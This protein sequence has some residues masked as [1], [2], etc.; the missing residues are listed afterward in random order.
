M[1]TL[2]TYLLTYLL[3]GNT[4]STAVGCLKP[5][6][7]CSS[8]LLHKEANLRSPSIWSEFIS[9]HAYVSW[10]VS[11]TQLFWQ[12]YHLNNT[13]LLL[14]CHI[15]RTIAWQLHNFNNTILLLRWH[16]RG[17]SALVAV[18][19]Y[20]CNP[21]IKLTFPPYN[22]SIGPPR[23]LSTPRALKV[24]IETKPKKL[25]GREIGVCLPDLHHEP[26]PMVP[27]YS[28]AP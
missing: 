15:R 2:L 13:I 4:S 5:W 22:Y 28:Q 11:T 14:M 7:L 1:H 20:Q 8:A 17:A 27:E 12:L 19:P 3:V 10:S 9:C 23:E 21:I 24:K 18:P 6:S 16:C 25:V 26:F